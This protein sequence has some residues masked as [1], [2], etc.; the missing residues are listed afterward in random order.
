MASFIL[1]V[2]R[3]I[4]LGV[5]LSIHTSEYLKHCISSSPFTS[6]LFHSIS[7]GSYHLARRT[8]L[9]LFDKNA[10]SLPQPAAS[11]RTGGPCPARF[12]HTNSSVASLGSI[13]WTHPT[14]GTPMPRSGKFRRKFEAQYLE[15]GKDKNQKAN[16]SRAQLNRVSEI[17]P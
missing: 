11:A 13:P 12:S 4:D 6:I 10:P 14:T 3:N 2:H 5:D 17:L 8:H 9:L 15:W 7:L 1:K 16:K